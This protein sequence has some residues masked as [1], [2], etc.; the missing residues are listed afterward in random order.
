M[1]CCKLKFTISSYLI[2]NHFYNSENMLPIF[3][4]ECKIGF[5]IHTIELMRNPQ[6]NVQEYTRELI[7]IFDKSTK[8]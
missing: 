2:R 4:Y 5:N 8:K 1:V 6:L 3:I 7:T